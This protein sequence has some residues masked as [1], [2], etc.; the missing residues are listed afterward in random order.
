MGLMWVSAGN[1]IGGIGLGF[2]KGPLYACALLGIGPPMVIIM[3]IS[4]SMI[5]A[6]ASAS[7]KAYG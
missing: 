4:T 3:G 7:L 6:G 2:F 5:M 1:F